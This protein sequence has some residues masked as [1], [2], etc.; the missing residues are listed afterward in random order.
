[1]KQFAVLQA[2]YPRNRLLWLEAGATELRAG[3]A[4]QAD[5]QLS[6]GIA[7]LP[8]DD[9]PRMFGEEA[10]WYYKRGAARASLGRAAE[11][12][13]DLRKSVSSEGRHWVHGRAHL[14]LGK[15]ALK[16]GNRPAANAEFRQAVTLGE[17]DNDKPTSDE[18][19]RLIK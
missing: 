13:Q 2:Q 15:L 8:D 11:A 14:E 18:A 12:E 16:A 17:R 10:L 19:R 3:R 9:R 5:A 6:Q 1:V 7:T 4:A